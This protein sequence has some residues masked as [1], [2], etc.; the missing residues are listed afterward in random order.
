MPI[1]YVNLRGRSLLERIVYAIL[2]L[3]LVVLGFF[4]LAAALA[5]GAILAVVVLARLWWIRRRLR[6]AEEERFITTE[7]SVVERERPPAPSLPQER[8]E[9]A[10]K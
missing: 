7:Y 8:R 10:D 4:F 9:P 3:T 5:A 1:L 2:G 6:R